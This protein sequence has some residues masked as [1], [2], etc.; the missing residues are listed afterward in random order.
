MMSIECRY[1]NPFAA[2]ASLRGISGIE[3]GGKKEDWAYE[4]KAVHSGIFRREVHDVPIN[5]P[6]GDDA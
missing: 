3:E 4:T 1:C 6:L 5:H 2:S